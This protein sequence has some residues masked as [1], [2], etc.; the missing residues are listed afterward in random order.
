MSAYHPPRRLSWRDRFQIRDGLAGGMLPCGCAFGRYLTYS[1]AVLT[2][3][4]DASGCR[5]GHLAD[6]VLEEPTADATGNL[7]LRTG[8]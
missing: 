3:I 8:N 1:G 6:R 4:D 7:E 2:V 5:E